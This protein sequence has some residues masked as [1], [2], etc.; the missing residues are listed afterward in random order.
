MG[1]VLVLRALQTEINFLRLV[2]RCVEFCLYLGRLRGF[3]YLLEENYFINC[4]T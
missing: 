2:C 1:K 3:L 4:M